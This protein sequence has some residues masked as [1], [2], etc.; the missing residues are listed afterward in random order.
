MEGFL[1]NDNG[2]LN[3]KGEI[4]I[5]KPEYQ[6]LSKNTKLEILIMLINWANDEISKINENE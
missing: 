4:I 5:I 3:F 1:I 6:F 2:E